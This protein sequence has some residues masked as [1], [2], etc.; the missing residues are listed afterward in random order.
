MGK[1][2]PPRLNSEK[3]RVSAA[4]LRAVAHPERLRII[5]L[6]HHLRSASVQSIYTELGL[7]QSVVSQHLRV[8]RDSGL[9]TAA[10][11][12]KNV[13]YLLNEPLL[14]RTALAASV[15]AG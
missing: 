7:E 14:L 3:L 11:Q 15:L 8:L 4:I 9:V 13:I 2:A 12:G 5:R 6:V 1:T 10:R